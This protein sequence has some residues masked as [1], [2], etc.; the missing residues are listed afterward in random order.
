VRR[1]YE[2]VLGAVY[3]PGGGL[4]AVEPPPDRRETDAPR[5]LATSE[6]A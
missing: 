2:T 6:P 4:V 5:E 1:H 3:D